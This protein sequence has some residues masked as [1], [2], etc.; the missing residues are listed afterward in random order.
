MKQPQGAGF[1][2]HEIKQAI[3]EWGSDTPAS[4]LIRLF[5]QKLSAN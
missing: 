5:E 1:T 2:L 4:E 3:D